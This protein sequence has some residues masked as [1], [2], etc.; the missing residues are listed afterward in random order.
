MKRTTLLLSV[1]SLL[2][3]GVVSC[4][5]AEEAKAP[6]KPLISTTIDFLD[7]AFQSKSPEGYL[8][9]EEYESHFK[10]YASAGIKRVNLRTNVIG[11]TFQKSAYTNQYGVDGAWH[12]MERGGSERLI[13]TLQHYDPLAE[14]IRLAHKYGMEA[15]CWENTTDEGGGAPYD[16]NL[17]PDDAKADCARTGGSPLVDPFFRAHP[18]CWATA[19][20]VDFAAIALRNYRAQQHP[21]GKIVFESYR[22]D[23]PP[24]RFSREDIDLYYSYDNL[25]YTR[26]DGP[27]EF[28][29]SQTDDGRNVLTLSDLEI[30]APFV[31]IAP[32]T[33]YDY[34]R[35]FTLAIKGH[36]TSGRAYNTRGEEIPTYW[37]A[38]MPPAEYGKQRDQPDGWQENTS[39]HF[40]AMPS[41]AVDYGQYQAG[42]FVGVFVGSS[43]LTGIVE[44]CDP[45]AM[46]HKLDK[47]GELAKYPFDGFRLTLNSHSDGDTPDRFSYH[48]A[49]R[50]RLMK[51]TGKDIWKDELPLERIVAERA[52]G[53]AEYAEACKKLIG[54]RPLYIYGWRPGNVEF[55]VKNGRTNMGT[56][57][58][59]YARLIQNGTVAGVVMYEDFSDY[60]TPEVTGGRKIDLGLYRCMET[61]R[62]PKVLDPNLVVQD[63]PNLTEMDYYGA[64]ELGDE[65]IRR[66]KQYNGIA[67]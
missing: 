30:A 4:A 54:D 11:V 25:R 21:V 23:R 31:K 49:L 51:S 41:M 65:F 3:V 40:D 39:L 58:W 9:L 28:A 35:N 47:F 32:K 7:L 27:M 59:P 24:I 53:F 33:H 14:T 34:E 60:F 19:K 44:F 66:F 46:R 67:E 29:A 26:Y 38:N 15:W 52:A 55:F 36:L 61:G 1:L 18:S 10:R 62:R 17:V 48:P 12:Y 20:P 22:R 50:E 13:K 8:T 63:S 42:F 2:C 5:R 64:V 37:G 43:Y 56:L 6:A 16:L 45:V 57:I